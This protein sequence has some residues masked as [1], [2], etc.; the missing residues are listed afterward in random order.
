M[1]CSTCATGYVEYDTDSNTGNGYE[2]C[3]RCPSNCNTC[4][5]DGA[6]NDKTKCSNGQCQSWDQKK[7]YTNGADGTCVVCPANCKVCT[8]DSSEE[9][10]IC[11]D[12]E[13]ADGFTKNPDSG[14]CEAC[15]ANCET[16]EWDSS[17][18]AVVCSSGGCKTG[19]GLTLEK[20]CSACPN[21]CDSCTFD[22]TLEVLICDSCSS[23]YR[24]NDDVCAACPSN[25]KT[26]SDKSGSM[27]CSAC[28]D[29]Y[30]LRSSDKV[31]VKCPTHCKECDAKKDSVTCK[32]CSIGY[33]IS[34]DKKSCV[35]CTDAAFDNCATCGNSNATTDIAECLSC[36]S[37][38]VLKDDASECLD[39]SSLDCPGGAEDRPAECSSCAAT[40]VPSEDLHQCVYNCFV[41]GDIAAGVFVEQSQCK[42]DNGSA[43][44]KAC[45]SGACFAKYKVVGG[46]KMVTAGCLEPSTESCSGDI[47]NGETCL[48]SSGLDLC[49]RCCNG[50]KCNEFVSTLDGI[51]DSAAIPAVSALFITLAAFL[52]THIC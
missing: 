24:S 34:G 14:E 46:K 8:Y 47:E 22:E 52:S 40:Y 1:K 45:A 39:S 27:I 12:G 4:T 30:A 50:D 33:S 25:C 26:C 20:E 10:T 51:P 41:C 35:S 7:A 23:G 9:K 18:S 2:Q 49:T 37:G 44:F 21:H 6:D 29:G 48:S 3:K 43:S 19:Y 11:T 17:S 36:S 32:K 15:S 13:C 38:Y 42:T 5:V 16:C 28:N 31:C